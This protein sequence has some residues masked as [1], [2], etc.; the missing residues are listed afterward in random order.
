[1]V[2]MWLAHMGPTSIPN[3]PCGTHIDPGYGANMVT[4]WDL[5]GT[6][7]FL[8]AGQV[9]YLELHNICVNS[10]STFKTVLLVALEEGTPSDEAAR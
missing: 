5:Y 6:Y 8:L 1:M 3:I 10:Y 2:F 9:L 7:E 4:T